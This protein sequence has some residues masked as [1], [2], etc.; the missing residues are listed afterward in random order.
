MNR[1]VK[2]ANKYGK[3]DKHFGGSREHRKNFR[4]QGNMSYKH[5]WEQGVLLM[6]NKG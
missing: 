1:K 4:D 3:N 2:E 5:F 6:G